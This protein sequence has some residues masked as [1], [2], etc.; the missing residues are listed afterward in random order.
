MSSSRFRARLGS[1]LP[2]DFKRQPNGEPYPS[3]AAYEVLSAIAKWREGRPLSDVYVFRRYSM[4][5]RP[6]ALSETFE[7]RG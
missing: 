3:G 4:S 1:P 6:T 2:Q 7:S 5:T